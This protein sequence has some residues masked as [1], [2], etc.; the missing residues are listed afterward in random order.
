M[1]PPKSS[2]APVS[3]PGTVLDPKENDLTSDAMSRQEA[4]VRFANIDSSMEKIFGLL[5]SFAQGKQ[6]QAASQSATVSLKGTAVT[7]AGGETPSSSGSGMLHTASSVG[8]AG[9]VHPATAP[10]FVK[11]ASQ[12]LP[13]T[14]PAHSVASPA[15][16]GVMS[17]NGDPGILAG[18]GAKEASPVVSPTLALSVSSALPPVPG[19]LV[20]KIKKGQY[21]D[22]NLLRPCNLKKLPVSEPSQ[23]QLNKIFKSELQPIRNFNDWAEAWAVHGA[24]IAKECPGKAADQ[25]SYFLL[26]SSAHRDVAGLGWLEYDV[27]FRKHAAEKGAIIWGEVMPTLWMTTVVA[28]GSQPA[29]DSQLPKP[30][31]VCFKWNSSSCTF[32]HCRFAHVC[33][34]CRGSHQ[35]ADCP[36]VAASSGQS[37][38]RRTDRDGSPVPKKVSRK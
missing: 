7:T 14:L 23:F 15:P 20:E 25:F 2:G 24:V 28:K 11:L 5:S 32:P 33:A 10:S 27:A 13:V 30:K 34:N 9:Q 29:K 3:D 18:Q 6:Q 4:M 37:T 31:S 1:D 19:Y 38:V 16:L 21:V 8:Q 26:L 17:S 36:S 22:F 35:K 12:S